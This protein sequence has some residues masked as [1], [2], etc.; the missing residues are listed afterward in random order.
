MYNKLAMFWDKIIVMGLAAVEAG[1][2]YNR[3][4]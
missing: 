3:S 1:K 2:N 4:I